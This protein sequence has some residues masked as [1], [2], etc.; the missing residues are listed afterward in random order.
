MGL[1]LGYRVGVWAK[2][3][4]HNRAIRP[5]W[6]HQTGH[7]LP[8]CAC[9]LTVPACGAVRSPCWRAVICP[10]ARVG[11]SHGAIHTNIF[12]GRG[13][14]INELSRQTERQGE[15][16]ISRRDSARGRVPRRQAPLNKRG[17]ASTST[18]SSPI[19]RGAAPRSKSDEFF[20]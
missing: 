17:R 11:T 8:P 20:E 16:D 10:A 12:H 3:V 2:R 13:A 9:S 15:A 5:K 6:V 1:G 14:V 18:K 7:H 4:Q 19:D